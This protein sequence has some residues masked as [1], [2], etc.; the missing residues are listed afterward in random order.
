MSTDA[1]ADDDL[2]LGLTAIRET[3]ICRPERMASLLSEAGLELWQ[4]P[5]GF[6]AIRLRR[7]PK[8]VPTTRP[9]SRTQRSKAR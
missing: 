5:E 7:P 8:P 4:A 1:T 9:E 6:W 3:A 2:I